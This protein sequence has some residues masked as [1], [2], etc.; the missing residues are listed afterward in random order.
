MLNHEG[1]IILFE[2]EEQERMVLCEVLFHHQKQFHEEYIEEFKIRVIDDEFMIYNSARYPVFQRIGDSVIV[3]PEGVVGII[4]VKKK[5]KEID[6]K[7]EA[8]ALKKVSKLCQC[9]N[10][11]GKVI[12][13]PFWALVSMDSFEKEKEPTD[14]WIYNKLLEVYT[15]E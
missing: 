13:G 1:E 15:Q 7:H 14:E 3:P 5:L 10:D 8:T 11:E 4:S 2:H 6:V 12:R 9:C